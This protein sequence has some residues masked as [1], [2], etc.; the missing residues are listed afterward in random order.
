[1]GIGNHPWLLGDRSTHQYQ[2]QPFGEHNYLPGIQLRRIGGRLKGPN[3]HLVDICGYHIN[4]MRHRLMCSHRFIRR[5]GCLHLAWNRRSGDAWG[6][7]SGGGPNSSRGHVQCDL[8]PPVGVAPQQPYRPGHDQ[9]AD[10]HDQEN[11]PSPHVSF[12]IPPGYV[13]LPYSHPD[14]R[15]VAATEDV[16]RSIPLSPAHTGTGANVEQ[17]DD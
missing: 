7:C 6:R 1:M 16:A 8:M 10:T 9:A 15:F 11:S 5:Y 14:D 12:P 17:D 3:S 2:F 4:Q 13:R